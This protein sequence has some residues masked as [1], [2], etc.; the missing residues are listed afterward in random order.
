MGTHSSNITGRETITKRSTAIRLDAILQDWLLLLYGN[1][2]RQFRIRTQVHRHQPSDGSMFNSTPTPKPSTARS[3]F[4]A[5]LLFG[6]LAQVGCRNAAYSDLYVENM[7]AEIRQLEDQLYEYDNEYHLL[8]QE[9]AS[10]KAENNQL[11]SNPAAAQPSSG[12]IRQ[13]L[14]PKDPARSTLEFAP[15]E[16]IP[17]PAPNTLPAPEKLPTKQPESILEPPGAS[18]S[19]PMQQRLQ[20]SLPQLPSTPKKTEPAND[21]LDIPTIDPGTPLPPGMPVLKEFSSN[22]QPNA[23]PSNNLELNLSRIEIP[24]QLAS[25]QSNSSGSQS[26]A[27]QLSLNPGT[28]AQLKLGSERPADMRIVEIAFHPTLSRAANFDEESDDDGLYLVLQPKN[29]EGQLVPTFADLEIAVLDPTRTGDNTRI[30]RW[31]YSAVEVKSKFQPIGSSQ[32]IHLTLPWN[33]PD[34]SGDR[35]QVYARYTL[36]DGRQVQSEKTVFVSGK[37][38]MK[39]VWVPRSS[40]ASQVVTASGQSELPAN[41]L[42]R[43]AVIGSQATQFDPAPTPTNR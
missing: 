29:V 3:L 30:G 14:T 32:G 27:S 15:R 21:L 13:L 9:L 28:R 26:S 38:S 20:N 31:S 1:I 19:A 11:R 40:D 12:G 5:S 39:T 33:G 25:A 7:A 41:S 17:D 8:E 42:N 2:V 43:S 18:S 35:V 6:V 23:A 4:K 37:T 10:L 24:N 22:N 16:T 34:P 36:P